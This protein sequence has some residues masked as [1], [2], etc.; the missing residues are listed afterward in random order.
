MRSSPSFSEHS[1]AKILS[2]VLLSPK[3]NEFESQRRFNKKL[4][5]NKPQLVFSAGGS[6]EDGVFFRE[7]LV[8]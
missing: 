2:L 4:N 8:R 5:Y 3:T 7:V 6:I 1:A